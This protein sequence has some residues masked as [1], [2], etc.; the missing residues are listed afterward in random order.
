MLLAG[1]PRGHTVDHVNEGRGDHVSNLR[2]ITGKRG[3]LAPG[4]DLSACAAPDD[5]G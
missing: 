1:A 5:R 4:S 2:E 3:R